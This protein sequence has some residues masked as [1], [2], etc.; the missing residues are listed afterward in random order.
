MQKRLGLKVLGEKKR[1]ILGT[2]H[3]L[4]VVESKGVMILMVFFWA[5]V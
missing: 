5:Y 3:F 2:N 1:V 4:W